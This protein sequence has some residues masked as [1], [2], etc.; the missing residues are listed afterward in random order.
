M[1]SASLGTGGR[2][3]SLDHLEFELDTRKFGM[4]SDLCARI[5]KDACFGLAE[6]GP[7]GFECRMQWRRHGV[8]QHFFA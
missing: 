5:G 1:P 2:S 7:G 6:F 4:R 3:N 8:S